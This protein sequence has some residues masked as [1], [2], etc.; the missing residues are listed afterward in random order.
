[1]KTCTVSY[2][3]NRLKLWCTNNDEYMFVKVDQFDE[4]LRLY[5]DFYSKDVKSD[6]EN[7]A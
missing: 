3:L 5:F 2:W 1:M 4:V 7:C 6:D